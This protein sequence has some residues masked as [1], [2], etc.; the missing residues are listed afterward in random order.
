MVMKSVSF[1]RESVVL[2]GLMLYLLITRRLG[3]DVRVGGKKNQALNKT[4]E[5]HEKG[6]CWLAARELL[7]FFVFFTSPKKIQ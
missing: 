2:L 1:E 7:L 5:W 3:T 4:L 6:K